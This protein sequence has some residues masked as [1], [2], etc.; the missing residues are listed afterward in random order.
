M[1][2]KNVT[3]AGGGT[4]GS[5][6]AWQT[7]FMGFNVTVYDPFEKGIDNCKSLHKKYADLFVKDRGVAQEKTD[8]ALQRLSYSTDLK[9]AVADA[10]LI[11]ESVPENAEIK[12]EFYANLAKVAPEKTIFTSNSSTTLPSD[13]AKYTGR[14]EKFLALHFA[15][16]IWDA[17]ISEIMGHEGTDPK[18][19][20]QVVAFSREIGMVPIP[21]HKEQNGYVLNSMLSPFLTAAMNL[22]VNGVSDHE[23]IDKTWMITSKATTGPFGTMD[24]IGM[25]T[26]YNV[27]QLWGEKTA[28]QSLLDNAA[29]IKK[30]Y[31]DKGKLGKN[32][33]EGFYTYPN[34]RYEDAD[35]LK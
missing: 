21:I 1:T 16:L 14:P 6:I 3:I 4:L 17:N 13:Y 33:G 8:Q 27:T 12:K 2:I 29:F 11:S 24:I 20:D 26:I 28:N 15:N 35:F 19:F 9:S 30:E 32:A 23:S 7:A 18:T 25:H 10:D 31:I 22:L 34:P 5:Q